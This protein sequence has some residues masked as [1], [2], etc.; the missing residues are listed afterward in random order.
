MLFCCVSDVYI[1]LPCHCPLRRFFLYLP[2][3]SLCNSLPFHSIC[4]SFLNL[5]C[6]SCMYS[7]FG[8]IIPFGSLLRHFSVRPPFFSVFFFPLV[9]TFCSIR[10]PQ[11]HCFCV[12]V[13]DKYNDNELNQKI[14]EAGLC[15]SCVPIYIYTPKK[16]KKNIYIYIHI[17]H[18]I[19]I[20]H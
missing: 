9:L 6:A 1:L 10:S 19:F 3:V 7:F 20:L 8:L 13:L 16:K 14:L 17:Y 18:V 15:Y 5:L 2:C 4:S 11:I 12:Y